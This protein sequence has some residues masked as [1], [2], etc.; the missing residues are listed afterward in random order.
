LITPQDGG[1]YKFNKVTNADYACA[2][3]GAGINSCAGTVPNGTPIDTWT[4]GVKTFTVTATD[5]AG[6]TTTRTVTYTSSPG[7]KVRD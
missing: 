5:A 1:T 2:D 6:N 4:K 7:G 3:G